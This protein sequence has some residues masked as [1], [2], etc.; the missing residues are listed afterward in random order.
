M[1][2]D[3]EPEP[4]QPAYRLSDAVRDDWP[5]WLLLA[6]ALGVAA[7]QYPQLPERVPI[8]WNAAGHSDGWGSRAFGTFGML[9]LFLG[10]YGALLVLPL[11][12]PRRASYGRFLPTFRALRLSVAVMFLTVWGTA[13]AAARGDQVRTDVIVPAA[14]SLLF[15]IVGNFLGRVRPNWFVGIRTPWSLANDEAWRL[16][17]RAAGPAW[18]LGGIV[19]LLGA[20]L[21]GRLTAVGMAVGPGG[22]VLY[23]V[24]YSYFAYRQSLRREESSLRAVV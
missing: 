11:V 1:T 4:A 10:I 19:G 14:V 15:V 16:T 21:G 6:L 13:L 22:A 3:L 7:W 18:V 12:D 8:H 5:V 2:E 17:H 9:G 24:V 20:L 23:S